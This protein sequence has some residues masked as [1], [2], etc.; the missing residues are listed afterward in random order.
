MG[1][2]TGLLISFRFLVI[3]GYVGGLDFLRRPGF[4]N[5]TVDIALDYCGFYQQNV[6]GL[7][8]DPSEM[9]RKCDAS[10]VIGGLAIR[11]S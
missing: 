11:F 6:C 5:S 3:R 9:A 8:M 2:W 4:G 10:K 7:W 1:A